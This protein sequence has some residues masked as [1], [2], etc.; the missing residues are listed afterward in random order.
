MC[1]K[2]RVLFERRKLN[3]S[4]FSFNKPTNDQSFEN[5]TQELKID[6]SFKNLI[7]DELNCLDESISYTPPKGMVNSIFEDIYED[8]SKF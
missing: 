7:E 5:I 2:S 6:K 1:V 3:L 8:G 4:I